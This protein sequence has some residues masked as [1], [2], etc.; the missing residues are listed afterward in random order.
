M[1]DRFVI[2][3]NVA[4]LVCAPNVFGQKRK[5]RRITLRGSLLFKLTPG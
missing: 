2:S 3:I 5:P 1:Y 4:L